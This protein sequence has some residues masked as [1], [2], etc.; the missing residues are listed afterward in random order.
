LQPG[1]NNRSIIELSCGGLK[2]EADSYKSD[3]MSF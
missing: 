1:S 3:E 2:L